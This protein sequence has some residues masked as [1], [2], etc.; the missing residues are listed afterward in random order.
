M[1]QEQT[2]HTNRISADDQQKIVGILSVLFP[3]A[4]IYLFGSQARGTANRISDID[5]AID[6]G[7]KIKAINRIAEARDM[8]NSS[9][10]PHKIDVLDFHSVSKI[11]KELI[12]KDRVIWKN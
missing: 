9:D 11:M 10:I 1:T 7:D 8:L 12:I 6:E 3:D 5:I 4:K 2:Q